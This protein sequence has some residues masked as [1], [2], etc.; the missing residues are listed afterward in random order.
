VPG[1]PARTR[2]TRNSRRIAATAVVLALAAGG[3]G[4]SAGFAT[5]QDHAAL[6]PVR[7]VNP[8]SLASTSWAERVFTL[9]NP[10][11]VDITVDGGGSGTGFFYRPGRIDT[12]AHV[13]STGTSAIKAIATDTKLTVHVHLADGRVRTGHVDAID[14][15]TDLAIISVPADL[16][17]RPLAFADS[18][19]AHPGAPVAVIGN[20]FANG[21][22]ISTGILSGTARNSR[23]AATDVQS[24]LLQTDAAVNPGNS[25]GPLLDASGAVLG[26]VTLRPDNFGG[27]NAEGMAFALP[28]HQ[29]RAAINSL[30]TTGKIAYPLLGV[31]LRDTTPDDKVH[32]GALV[33]QVTTDSGAA[34]AGINPGDTIT[35]VDGAATADGAGVIDALAGHAGGDKIKVTVVRKDGSHA[36]VTATLGSR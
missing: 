1:K 27:R 5:G 4:F 7:I 26:I 6:G 3:A 21:Q 32:P 2:L 20:P 28:A 9:A 18:T 19:T 35:R 10:A 15:R 11:V 13:V 23:F 25:G 24:L 14:A 34:K 30:E 22:S 8:T 31:T 16:G 36:T 29:V 12:N 17:I 33:G